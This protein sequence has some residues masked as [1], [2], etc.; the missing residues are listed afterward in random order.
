MTI[1]LHGK[2][3]T[4]NKKCELYIDTG[5][6]N[7]H[8][9]QITPISKYSKFYLDFVDKIYVCSKDDDGIFLNGYMCRDG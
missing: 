4:I 1:F 2:S 9:I 3:Y 5:Y 7:I 8:N 6:Y